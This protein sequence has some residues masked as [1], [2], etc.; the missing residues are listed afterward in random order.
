MRNQQE[1][2]LFEKSI[3]SVRTFLNTGYTNE[4]L[5]MINALEKAYPDMRRKLLWEKTE[6]YSKTDNVE[7]V[8]VTLIELFEI[9][10][11]QD[12]YSVL[13]EEFVNNCIDER[14]SLYIKN[15]EWLCESKQSYG[16]IS[17]KPEW[18]V[19]YLS[20]SLIISLNRKSRQFKG[21]KRRTIDIDE[22]NNRV[23]FV[24]GVAFNRQ[25]LEIA[26]TSRKENG[27]NGDQNAIYLAFTEW[28]S[29]VFLQ[30]T[31]IEDEYNNE[32]YVFVFGEEG[33]KK[34]FCDLSAA[35]PEKYVVLHNDADYMSLVD[36][37]LRENKNA[38]KAA[39]ERIKEYYSNKEHISDME[40]RIREHR[41]R[42]LFMTSRFTTVLQYHCRNAMEA[43]TEL[44]CECELMI[45]SGNVKIVSVFSIAEELERFYPDVLF[46]LDHFRYEN[47]DI[48]PEIIPF[49]TWIQDPMSHI[50]DP[51]SAKKLTGRDLVLNHMFTWDKM[52][53]LYPGMLVDAPVP[54]NEKIYK[55]YKLSNEEIEK[56]SA[57]ICFV[58]HASDA[59]KWIDDTMDRLNVHGE[60]GDVFRDLLLGYMELAAKGEFFFSQKEFEEYIGN[61]FLEKGYQ[62]NSDG[63]EIM[64]KETFNW[65]NQRVFRQTIVDWIIDA[66]FTNL[67]L[68][69]NGWKSNPKYADY[70][71][72]PAENGETLSKIYQASKVVVG[73]NIMTTS[74][75]RAWESMLSGA[76]YLSNY[77]PPECDW[78]DIRK[79]MPE[80]TVEYFRTRDELI[81]KLHYFIE[82][83]EERKAVANKCREEALKR[84]T[85]K[86]LMEKV[87]NI[88][89]ERL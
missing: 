65:F 30:S 77:I 81:E 28:E 6:L 86:A 8:I 49:I 18:I 39:K 43:A 88:L 70:A 17:E 45:E 56:Y 21:V 35:I 31:L 67:K 41:P 19:F 7:K 38:Y 78:C 34:C 44:G 76:F 37:V 58:C 36:E 5:Q 83:D 2:D 24:E 20:D 54:A 12:A 29:D 16:N 75:A 61:T 48:F 33:I 40:S 23:V 11:D 55:P 79:I 68:W 62:I 22:L 85:F 50:M 82:H 13:L 4:A 52:R 27:V 74:A 3:Q 71:M 15:R 1:L 63:L 72:G 80:G 57:D 42:I 10:Q 69:G 25:I 87:L 32:R 9:Y 64:A 73:N 60:V 14:L 59:D 84:M 51:E 89:P 47:G 66:G 26:K 46:L 53:E